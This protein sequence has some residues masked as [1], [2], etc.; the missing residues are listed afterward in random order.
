MNSV[1]VLYERS[2]QV[3]VPKEIRYRYQHVS[4]NQG[5]ES[6]ILPSGHRGSMS[7]RSRDI[8]GKRRAR[9][10]PRHAAAKTTIISHEGGIHAPCEGHTLTD[11]I[12]VGDAI[13]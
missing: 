1:K 7:A 5:R 3:E 12:G 4:A 2:A 8:C 13:R 6:G 11:R 9:L 10:L